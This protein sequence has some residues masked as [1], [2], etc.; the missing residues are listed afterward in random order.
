MN[1]KV[2][3]HDDI[4]AIMSRKRE[5]GEFVGIVG[6]VVAELFGS[7]GKLKQREEQHNLVTTNGDDYNV[8]RVIG[9]G[10][11]AMAGMKL[12]TATT[13]AAK[14]GAGSFIATA[15]YVS[16]SAQAFDATYPK[17]GSSNNIAQYQVTYA[18]GTAT[19]TNINRVGITDNVTNAGEADGTHTLATAV[20]SGAINKASGDTLVVVWNVTF[21]G[22]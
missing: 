14:T 1:N 16:G 18:P 15:D 12:G 20:F 6:Y 5:H 4:A 2:T 19:N 22:S 11:T 10:V 17:V 7:D 13:A 21:L 3:M 9:S 8:G